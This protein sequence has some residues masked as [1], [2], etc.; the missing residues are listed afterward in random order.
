MLAGGVGGWRCRPATGVARCP[1]SRRQREFEALL[2]QL[3]ADPVE[4]LLFGQCERAGVG[5]A[6]S[7]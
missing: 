2:A 6:L 1:I 3:L 5:Y 7:L 4:R